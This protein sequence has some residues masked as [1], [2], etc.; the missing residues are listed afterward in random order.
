[1]KMKHVHN[2]NLLVSISMM[3]MT[4][5][6]LGV[7]RLLSL[8][9]VSARPILLR[10]A[11]LVNIL[12]RYMTIII[13]GISLMRTSALYSLIGFIIVGRGPLC[14]HFGSSRCVGPTCFDGP[15][16]VL[17]VLCLLGYLLCYLGLV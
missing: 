13:L 9:S 2:H 3:S 12:C 10:P 7:T 14:C 8:D 1:M 17:C 11:A 16:G 5:M 4:I 15:M 6:I